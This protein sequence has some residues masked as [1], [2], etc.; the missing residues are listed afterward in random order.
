MHKTIARLFSAADRAIRRMP[1]RHRDPAVAALLREFSENGV[2]HLAPCPRASGWLAHAQKKAASACDSDEC[3][4]RYE[5]TWIEHNRLELSL[6]PHRLFKHFLHAL[7]GSGPYLNP[8]FTHLS[9]LA[10]GFPGSDSKQRRSNRKHVDGATR[11][12]TVI[13]HGIIVGVLLTDLVEQDRGN[14]VTWI[15]SHRITRDAFTRL[16][17]SPSEAELAA[18]IW[19]LCDE[20]LPML[21]MQFVGPAGSVIV[22]DHALHH[23]MAPNDGDAIRHAVFYRLPW[24]PTTRAVDAVDPNFFFRRA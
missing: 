13:W 24:L 7:L 5:G 10:P 18:R 14:P 6:P 16:G 11:E 9:S 21:P 15:G 20:P 8:D 3:K 2:V 12:M 19:V 17:P 1:A 4:R 23:G 22:M